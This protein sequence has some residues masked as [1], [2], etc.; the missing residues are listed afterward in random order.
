MS[1]QVIN[2]YDFECPCGYTASNNTQKSLDLME[3]LHS[4]RC[5]KYEKQSLTYTTELEIVNI[6]KKRTRK[7]K[8]L[9]DNEEE[10]I[11]RT[12]AKELSNSYSR[13]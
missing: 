10:Y 8:L 13:I 6:K 12:N 11:R 7:T 2:K 5:D 4:K 1:D 9:F 3:R